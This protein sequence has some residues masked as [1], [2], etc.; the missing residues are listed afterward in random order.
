V[1]VPSDGRAFLVQFPLN[2]P[3]PKALVVEMVKLRLSQLQ[4]AER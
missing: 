2:Q 1:L 4:R 3:I